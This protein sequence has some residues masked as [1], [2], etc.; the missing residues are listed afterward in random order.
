MHK[1]TL[2]HI[3]ETA[4]QVVIL[5]TSEIYYYFTDK[6]RWKIHQNQYFGIY[7][8]KIGIFWVVAP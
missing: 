7:K 1:I 8:R 5:W 2:K 4:L 6:N 3:D